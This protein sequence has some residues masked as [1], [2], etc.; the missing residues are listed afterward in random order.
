MQVCC[1]INYLTC[2]PLHVVS[3]K[4]HTYGSGSA[5][6]DQRRWS[7]HGFHQSYPRPASSA[8]TRGLPRHH[9]EPPDLLLRDEQALCAGMSRLGLGG[10][11]GAC[12]WVGFDWY[13]STSN[14]R[15]ATEV[16]QFKSSLVSSNA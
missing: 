9:S 6:A 14:S 5:A 3:P 11:F 2:I 8:V 12:A 13:C 16:V 1:V 15:A 7:L 10:R 4:G